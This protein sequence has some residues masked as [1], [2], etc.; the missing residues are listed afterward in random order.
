M[1]TRT[2]EIFSFAKGVVTNPT[3]Y[4]IKE[5]GSLFS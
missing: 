5:K 1:I 2:T 4:L 3:P